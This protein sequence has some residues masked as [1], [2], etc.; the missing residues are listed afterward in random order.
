LSPEPINWLTKTVDG[1]EM[2]MERLVRV[3]WTG[4]FD[5]SFRI[6][7][8]SVLPLIIKPYYLVNNRESERFERD[9]IQEISNLIETRSATRCELLP[10]SIIKN[11]ETPSSQEIFEAYHRLRKK[12]YFGGQYYWLARF[13]REHT[14]VELSII[15]DDPVTNHIMGYGGFK[16]I[17]DDLKGSF[18]VL[19]TENVPEDVNTLFG[20]YH[21]PLVGLTKQDLE[22]LYVAKGYQAVI[23]HTWFCGTPINGEPCGKCN[24]CRY[25]IE[26][27]LTDRFPKA[28]LRRYK[29]RKRLLKIQDWG[30]KII[31]LIK[32]IL[33]ALIYGMYI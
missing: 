30:K 17:T 16:E 31:R 29:W 7:Q 18:Y 3:F 22:S 4:G 12:F 13:A 6:M 1:Y 27:G 15:K 24:P 28:A 11:E 14:G 9:A 8:L 10:L 33:S 32:S 20:Y 26:G 19:D 2:R 25:T 23:N 5:S 21:F